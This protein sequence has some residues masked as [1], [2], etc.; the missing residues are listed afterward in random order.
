MVASTS[1]TPL[2]MARMLTSN[3]P[4]PRSNTHFLLRALFVDAVGDGRRGEL[5]D[6]AAHVEPGDDA[7]VLGGL[8]LRVIEVDRDW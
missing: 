2:S 4:P 3:V 5:V 8:A 1:K 6:Y 7:S